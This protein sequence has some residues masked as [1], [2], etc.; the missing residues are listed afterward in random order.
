[1]LTGNAVKIIAINAIV[2]IEP[3]SDKNLKLFNPSSK[4]PISKAAIKLRN[5]IEK[6]KV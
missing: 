3:E 1:M 4:K 6:Q 2:P 5:N